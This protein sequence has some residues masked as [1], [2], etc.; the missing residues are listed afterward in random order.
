MGE[1][2]MQVADTSFTK[3]RSGMAGT[4]PAFKDDALRFGV[5]SKSLADGFKRSSPLM[6]PDGLAEQPNEIARPQS[7]PPPQSEMWPGRMCC[8][9]SNPNSRNARASRGNVRGPR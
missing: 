5:E 7:A 8:G 3:M 4:A 6:A 1:Q 2:A 9:V